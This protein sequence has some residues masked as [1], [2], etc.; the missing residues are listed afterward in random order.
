MLRQRMV[1]GIIG[2]ILL[3]FFVYVGG[4]WFRLMTCI[5][6]SVGLYELLRMNHIPLWSWH[7]LPGLFALLWFLISFAQPFFGVDMAEG[8]PPVLLFG[9]LAY[10]FMLTV[11][12]KNRV[13]FD[14]IA[15]V[16]IT[17][18]YLM[19]GFG[20]MMETRF[21]VPNGM[22]WSYLILLLIW[23][24][25]TGA[26]FSGKHFGK[27]RLWPAISPKKT[28]E[29]ALGGLLF[30]IVVVMVWLSVFPFIT[31]GHGIVTAVVVAVVAQFGDLIISAMKRHYNTKDTGSI[32]PGHGGVMDRFDS[33]L[34]V[35]PVLHLLQII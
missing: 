14:H 20:Y 2:G 10:Y 11:M 22:W 29:G 32:L 13:T 21:V 8:I 6:A 5:L 1:T 35:F 16:F 9:M 15:F 12:S 17:V 24:A 33:L 34:F 25:D 28:V 31:Y 18:L 30:A 19:F 27:T 4:D 7:G 26:Y 23:S 3:L